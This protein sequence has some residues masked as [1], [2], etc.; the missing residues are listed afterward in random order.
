MKD[1]AR[2]ALENGMVI[3]EDIY[4]YQNE[5]ILAKDTAVDEKVIKKLALHSIICV[6][7]KE[8]IDFATTH[9][10]KVRLSKA[11]QTFQL[12]YNNC[13]PIYAKLM[14][15]FVETGVWKSTSQLNDIY[16]KLTACAGTGES[17]LDFLYNML[18]REDAMTHAHCLNS[19][20]IAGV[21]GTW[22]ELS[23]EDMRLLIQCAFFYDIGKLKIPQELLWKSDKLTDLEFTTLKTHTMLGFDLLKDQ[24]LDEHV[25]KATLMHHERCDGSGYPSK[26][27]GDKIDIFA[28]YIAVIDAYE[29][30]TSARTYRQPLNP[31]QV[32]ENFERDGYEKYERAI[33]TPILYHIAATQLGFTVRLSD[34]TE[35]KIMHLNKDNLSRPLLQQED[36][37]LIDLS[38]KPDLTIT[39]IF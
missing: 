22:W 34:D 28:K 24:S 18:P 11:F 5:L 32:I 6:P 38:S 20:L 35:A 13:M 7:V 8:E 12:T 21:F 36:G 23:E 31:F 37:S 17:L 10:E 16:T 30:M 29:A 2:M 4:N 19:A 9:F 27:K 25:I 26:L 3:G 14:N 33:L 15:G 1:V 39:A